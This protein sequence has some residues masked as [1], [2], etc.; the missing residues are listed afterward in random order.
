[1]PEQVTLTGNLPYTLPV[2]LAPNSVHLVEFTQNA[3]GGHT[4]TYCGQPVAVDLAAGA[5]TVVELHPVAGGYAVIG[6][7]LAETVSALLPAERIGLV[8]LETSEKR[9][10]RV[11]L[12]TKRGLWVIPNPDVLERNGWEATE[13]PMVTERDLVGVA[14]LGQM[15]VDPERF[16]PRGAAVVE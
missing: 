13:V 10:F 12:R 1:M 15:S 5:S 4:V 14:L 2:G 8:A 16:G 6:K 9:S 3:T 7:V 11:F